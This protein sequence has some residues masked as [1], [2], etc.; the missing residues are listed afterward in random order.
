MQLKAS[1]PG[2]LMLLGEYAV[3]YGKHALVC[4][5][6]KRITILLTPR[7]DERIEV[8]SDV[9]GHYATTLSE[10]KIEK[11]FQ[12]VLG[13]LKHFQSKLRR[14]CDIEI[15]SA[16]SDK[17]GLGSSAAVTVAL[18]GAI[19]TWLGIRTSPLDLAR[20]ARTI[21]REV[22]GMIGS[23]AD[24][25]AAVYGGVI[26]YQAQPLAVEK[27][28]HVYPLTA[29]YAGFKTPTAEAIKQVQQRF[30]SYP[31][32]LRS[33]TAS[34]GQ[35]AFEGMQLMRKEDWKG[36][37]E[38]FSIQQGMMQSLGVSMPLLHDMAEDLRKQS[39]I[40]GAKISGAGLGDCVI[41]LGE[42]TPEYEYVG[43]HAGVQRIPVTMTLQGV[44]C[45]KI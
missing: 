26:G 19:I 21:V 8:Q 27:F 39:S 33:L 42:V 37:G 1:A 43:E 18:T 4:A 14:G 34:I 15:T 24:V 30:A 29:L 41:G 36:L 13:A 38:L 22:Q 32:L 40:L 5:I 9:H 28:S 17:L 6:D 35:C 31:T 16:F 7:Q 23:G 20:I 3:L 44:Q 25:A 11:P 10:L 12:F 2:T 45:E